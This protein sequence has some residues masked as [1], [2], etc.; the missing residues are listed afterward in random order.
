MNNKNFDCSAI[1]CHRVSYVMC[2]CFSFNF[3]EQRCAIVCAIQD[4]NDLLVP[5]FDRNLQ[6]ISLHSRLLF[7]RF[8][9]GFSFVR[10]FYR[11]QMTANVKNLTQHRLR[12]TSQQR[13]KPAKANR[14]VC[15]HS[16]FL[17][18]NSNSYNATPKLIYCFQTYRHF[19]RLSMRIKYFGYFARKLLDLD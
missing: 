13:C 15:L 10:I 14:F 18:A 8:D 4:S 16:L 19:V 3:G 11:V 17:S 7:S 2:M 5:V 12:G 6:T 9:C 1:H